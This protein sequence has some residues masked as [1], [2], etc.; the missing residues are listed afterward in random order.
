MLLIDPQRQDR[1]GNENIF[2]KSL[3]DF[4][5]ANKLRDKVLSFSDHCGP[6][7]FFSNNFRRASVKEYVLAGRI[8]LSSLNIIYLLF[9]FD[10]VGFLLDSRSLF[11]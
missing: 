2:D 6:R 1:E 11:L 7:F 4:L 5:L 8:L 3:Y 10:N 9:S